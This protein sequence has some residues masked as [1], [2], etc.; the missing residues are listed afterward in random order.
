MHTNTSR[1]A[2]TFYLKTWCFTCLQLLERF[3]KYTR[4]LGESTSPNPKWN[5]ISIVGLIITII[6]SSWK[7]SWQLC[8]KLLIWSM[9]TFKVSA[10]LVLHL[11]SYYHDYCCFC[12]YSGY[13]AFLFCYF[14]T[15]SMFVF[16]LQVLLIFK[17][18]GLFGISL[19]L[20]WLASVCHNNPTQTNCAASNC[21]LYFDSL[22]SILLPIGY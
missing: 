21:I 13:L 17:L 6:S 10:P 3:H 2:H 1:H 20:S 22:H 18:C 15:L 14:Y 12:H 7:G 8:S 9:F 5:I 11:Y 16:Q 4:S 19:F